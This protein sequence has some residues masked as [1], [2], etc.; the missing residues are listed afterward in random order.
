MAGACWHGLE[1]PRLRHDVCLRRPPPPS[2]RWPRPDPSPPPPPRPPRPGGVP[3]L[4]LSG[5][6]LALASSRKAGS[7]G[8]LNL[9]VAPVNTAGRRRR[10][11]SPRAGSDRG[12]DADLERTW[13]GPGA[14]L[15]RTWSGAGA[16]LERSWSGSDTGAGRSG[17]EPRSAVRRCRAE[18][19]AVPCNIDGGRA[20]CAACGVS[21]RVGRYG[22]RDHSSHWTALGIV[23][24]EL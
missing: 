1:G 5:P 19:G 9:S 24:C 3:P 15:E 22:I 10:R 4:P 12:L 11:H 21:L 18:G 23:R 7:G 2:P 14:E 16:E 6:G 20:C 13:S 17:R 8:G